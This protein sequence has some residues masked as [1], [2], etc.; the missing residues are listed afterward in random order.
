MRVLG[1]F[2][3]EKYSRVRY[4]SVIYV[5][6]SELGIGC[7]YTGDHKKLGRAILTRLVEAS[8]CYVSFEACGLMS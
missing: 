3:W 8:G 1:F 7:A 6:S 5:P 2:G 4:I